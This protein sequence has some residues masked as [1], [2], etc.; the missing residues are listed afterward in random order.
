MPEDNYLELIITDKE[1][2]FL[3]EDC[4][5]EEQEIISAIENAEQ[6]DEE[7]FVVSMTE[8]ELKVLH[9]YLSRIFDKDVSK[10]HNKISEG[11]M[12]RIEKLVKI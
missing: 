5:I 4:E 7:R 8:H 2:V 9:R 1:Q 11:M 3:I 12:N 10:K 6:E